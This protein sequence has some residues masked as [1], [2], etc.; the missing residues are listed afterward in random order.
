MLGGINNL[1]DE[2]FI[3]RVKELHFAHKAVKKCRKSGLQ[4]VLVSGKKG[5]GK[6]TFLRQL[7]MNLSDITF[8]LYFRERFHPVNFFEAI[9]TKYTGIAP[10]I[11][12][13]ITPGEC[14]ILKEELPIFTPYMPAECIREQQ[15]SWASAFFHCLSGMLNIR[16][17][18]FMFDDF[19]YTVPS[20]ELESL[21]LLFSNRPVTIFLVA[22]EWPFNG[23]PDLKITIPPF[24]I[25]ETF[26]FVKNYNSKLPDSLITRI[27]NLSKGNPFYA[28]LLLNNPEE[29]A[30]DVDFSGYTGTILENKIKT[31]GRLGLK[32]LKTLAFIPSPIK[33]IELEYLLG[34]IVIKNTLKKL[35][36]EGV[37]EINND[38]VGLAHSLYRE[39]I[40]NRLVSRLESKKILKSIVSKALKHNLLAE[41]DIGDLLLQYTPEPG[42][43]ELY[44]K[45]LHYLANR[46]V[47]HHDY[48]AARRYFTQAYM[49]LQ[50]C[51]E[52]EEKLNFLKDYAWFFVTL[53]A[54]PNI[55]LNEV[56]KVIN[57][58]NSDDRK[59]LLFE[60]ASTLLIGG[61]FKEFETVER[62]FQSLI[63]T[64]ED[65]TLALLLKTRWY[66]FCKWNTGKAI[67]ILRKSLDSVKN[68]DLQIKLLYNLI[69]FEAN[70][71][72]D[73]SVYQR[74]LEL[75]STQIRDKWFPLISGAT[76]AIFL[77]K[78]RKGREWLDKV[79][80]NYLYD[81]PPRDYLVYLAIEAAYSLVVGDLNRFESFIEQSKRVNDI[82]K[83]PSYTQGIW[84]LEVERVMETGD[85]QKY[86][87]LSEEFKEP[88]TMLEN[89]ANATLY[90]KI[91]DAWYLSEINKN[92]EAYLLL[93]DIEKDALSSDPT[94]LLSPF[95]YRIKGKVLWNLGHRKRA[96]NAWEKGINILLA[97]K[98]TS[99]LMLYNREIARTT[100]IRDYHDKWVQ[101]AKEIGALKWI[102]SAGGSPGKTVLL[103]QKIKI[104]TLREFEVRLPWSTMS[105]KSYDFKYK[106]AIYV[107]AMLIA[108]RGGY[109]RKWKILDCIWPDCD[110]LNPLNV[111]LS[112]LRTLIH[113][114]SIET[115]DNKIR[116]NEDLFTIDAWEFENLVNKGLKESDLILASEYLH[117]SVDLYN[118]PFFN[119]LDILEIEDYRNYLSVLLQRAYTKLSL[120]YLTWKDYESSYQWGYR[121]VSH[122]PLNE[123]AHRAYILSLLGMGYR[124][125]A[126]NQYRRMAKI[127]KK[128]LGVSPSPESKRLI[129]LIRG[130]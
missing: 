12:R 128:E 88:A 84:E 44:F 51:R 106:K 11:S 107:L 98:H 123:E 7:N 47:K 130:D 18:V 87:R 77:G 115:Y 65:E 94:N 103:N 4:K 80:Y 81:L 95:F 40:R 39:Y 116:L 24:R 76:S 19:D 90:K 57:T 119:G 33:M 35:L 121:A 82:L 37:V 14:A 63:K 3:G 120:I 79:K 15:S 6:T 127:L 30:S 46:A 62:Q 34:N 108:S 2:A 96:M 100:K 49:Y 10:L 71:G 124:K 8:S 42:E 20:P 54:S 53:A 60:L 16:P 129:K 26:E 21:L 97:N 99:H 52:K 55:D 68:K 1:V 102:N 109:L 104:F 25:E 64:E 89:P 117:K 32:V 93:K 72:E 105:L 122:D 70:H 83:V 111:A 38:D 75:E 9:V 118:E 29:I 69:D 5:I 56:L 85:I 73:Q 66:A 92:K 17:V 114:N 48:E 31:G 112:N 78:L 91:A 23:D 43:Q 74:V 59:K 50:S 58:L 28:R 22:S 126:L 110:R 113:R 101:L 45:R 41:I 86:P 13:W 125:L 67:L 36:K 61:K 27:H